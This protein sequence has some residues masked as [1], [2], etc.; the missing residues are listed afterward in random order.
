M[1]RIMR[2]PFTNKLR[3]LFKWW[4]RT[5]FG[6]EMTESETRQRAQVIDT[7]AEVLLREVEAKAKLAEIKARQPASE[8]AALHLST[9]AG[10]YMTLMVTIF[11]FSC[12]Y[13]PAE[14]LGT[15]TGLVTL[16]VT[17]LA[18]ILKSIVDGKRDHE[19]NGNTHKD[20]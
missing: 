13:L 6:I 12:L 7:R 4:L 11:L 16:V 9:W 20:D 8:L 2:E 17:S 5:L 18:A 10:A 1:Y 19:D 14:S 15:I 3:H